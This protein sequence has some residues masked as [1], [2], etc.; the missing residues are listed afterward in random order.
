M[1]VHRSG[2]NS[3]PS[4]KCTLPVASVITNRLILEWVS[5]GCVTACTRYTLCCLAHAKPQVASALCSLR[6]TPPS[7]TVMLMEQL[8]EANSDA[9]AGAGHG[10]DLRCKQINLSRLPAGQETK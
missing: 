6:I 8:I 7:G 9:E 1:C 5:V 2:S 3:I 4:A 10:P